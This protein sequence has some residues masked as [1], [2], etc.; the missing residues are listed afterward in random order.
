MDCVRTFN[1]PPW[2]QY[3]SFNRFP[4]AFYPFALS[5]LKLQ[6]LLPQQRIG[7][8]GIT[9]AAAMLWKLNP[10]PH[11]GLLSTVA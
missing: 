7:P 6:Q 2:K 3:S 9:H 5:V 10:L 1:V 11:H 8:C 4:Y